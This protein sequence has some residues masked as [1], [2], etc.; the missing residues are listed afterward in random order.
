MPNRPAGRAA[1]RREAAVP[2]VRSPAVRGVG[3]IRSA[4]L[5]LAGVSLVVA[6]GCGGGA[7]QD[8]REPSGTFTVDISE[9]TFPH[10][11]RVAGQSEMRITVRNPTRRAI[12]NVAVTIAGA[13]GSTP[14]QA[15]GEADP[16]AGL[17][18]SS[19]PVWIV[20]EGPAGGDTAYVNTWALGRLAADQEKTFVWRV[21]PVVTGTHTV[22]YRVAAGLNGR[23][24][25]ALAGGGPPAGTFTVNIS[26]KP[27]QA[28]V[29]PGGN[30]TTA[31]SSSG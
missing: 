16:Q 30:V 25:A 24:H 9:A 22:R 6:A 19:R 4:G 13:D 31:P 18:S 1:N 10:S 28:G 11:Q 14:A 2:L 7:H 5:A 20:D 21:T 27:A 29:G 26:G 23:A 3:A 12:P 17:A 15:F 8:A